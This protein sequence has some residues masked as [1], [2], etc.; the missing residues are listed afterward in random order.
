MAY[1]GIA[2]TPD[3]PYYAVIFTN[4][5]AEHLEGYAETAERMVELARTIDG[6]LGV[7][8]V[9]AANGLGITVSYWRD[10]ASIA[11]W[12]SQAEHT[13]ARAQGR[14]QW[15]ADFFVRVARVERAYDRANTQP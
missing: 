4:Q 8:S 11:Q 10:E 9:R 3:P 14:E 13:L 5:H 7:E 1:P 2:H 6:F 15:Y 12:K